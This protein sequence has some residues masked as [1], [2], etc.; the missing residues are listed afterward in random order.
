M[1]INISAF[2]FCFFLIYLI[3]SQSQIN[4]LTLYYC[5]HEARR[6]Q[7]QKI[8]T[9]TTQSSTQLERIWSCEVSLAQELHAGR[10]KLMEWVCDESS[11]AES[12][13]WKWGKNR[14]ERR[15]SNDSLRIAR[16]ASQCSITKSKD[17]SGHH[18]SSFIKH[19]NPSENIATSIKQRAASATNDFIDKL[20]SNNYTFAIKNC[21]SCWIQSNSQFQ[22]ES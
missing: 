18:W 4:N 12:C 13:R 17:W 6:R 10:E 21:H 3:I 22:N 19:T 1:R 8:Q 2:F 14:E 7:R 5:K 16:T 15:Q 20:T 11:L 9:E